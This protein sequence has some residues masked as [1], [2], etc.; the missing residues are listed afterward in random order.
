[1]NTG[2]GSMEHVLA[3][4]GSVVVQVLHGLGLEG[5]VLHLRHQ[6]GALPGVL[7]GLLVT[8]HLREVRQRRLVET[9]S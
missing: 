5:A 6:Q 8:D 4:V 2:L 7:L 9:L 3:G 1:M